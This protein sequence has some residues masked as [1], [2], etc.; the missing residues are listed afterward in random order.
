MK[1]RKRKN[2]S[3]RNVVKLEHTI[4]NSTR[5]ASVASG[6]GRVETNHVSGFAIPGV[7]INS[8]FYVHFRSEVVAI[9]CHEAIRQVDIVEQLCI[10]LRYCVLRLVVVGN[11]SEF[12]S[13]TIPECPSLRSIR[14]RT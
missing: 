1:L 12:E 2:T 6:R 3:Y 11:A 14:F 7:R 5:D 10:D 4:F 13:E 9:Q 8:D